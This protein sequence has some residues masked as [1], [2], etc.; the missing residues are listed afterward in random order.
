MKAQDIMTKM[1]ITIGPDTPVRAIATLLTEKRISGVPVLGNDG[2]VLGMVSHGDLLHRWEIGTEPKQKWWLKA[3]ADPDALARAY[4][5]THGLEAKDVMNRHVVSVSENAEMADVAAILDRNG[6]NRVPVM[7][8]GKLVGLITRSDLVKALS[9]VPEQA[10][11]ASADSGSLHH[12]I[13]SKMK[14]QQWLNSSHL[15]VIV[16]DGVVQVW[17]L[18]GSGDQR[19]ALRVL[20]EEINGVKSV[21]DHLMVGF[22]AYDAV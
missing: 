17:G 16:K 20:I 8:D 1:V 21:E 12:A 15:N 10:G 19:R 5:K 22:P 4:T 18:I 6:I 13:T 11:R 3:F 14:T 7:R 9:R 2:A